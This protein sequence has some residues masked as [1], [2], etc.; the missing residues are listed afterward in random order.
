MCN[1]GWVEFLSIRARFRRQIQFDRAGFLT[2][3]DLLATQIGGRQ[4]L[5]PDSTQS[6]FSPGARF[7][8][9]APSMMRGCPKTNPL[10]DYP[11]VRRERSDTR[12]A[13]RQATHRKLLVSANR[14]TGGTGPAAATAGM[15]SKPTDS[16]GTRRQVPTTGWGR[17]VCWPG[18][19]RRMRHCKGFQP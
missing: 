2:A 17:V 9:C 1:A 16:A 8:T 11:S 18:G 3:E 19:W 15:H 14:P 12:M 13:S 10:L 4:Q 7:S 6:V 5:Q